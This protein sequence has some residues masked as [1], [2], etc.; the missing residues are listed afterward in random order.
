MKRDDSPDPIRSTPSRLF[1]ELGSIG[2]QLARLSI[3][4]RQLAPRAS[5]DLRD[6]LVRSKFELGNLGN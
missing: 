2:L 6:A 1:G 5:A 4:A 3:R